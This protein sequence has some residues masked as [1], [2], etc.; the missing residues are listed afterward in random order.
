MAID[1]CV[2]AMRVCA[3]VPL[4]QPGETDKVAP[5]EETAHESQV[6]RLTEMMMSPCISCAY[7]LRFYWDARDGE[8]QRVAQYKWR[9]A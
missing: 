2:E 3:Y 7:I 8:R 6:T 4:F 1:D 5:M 9:G